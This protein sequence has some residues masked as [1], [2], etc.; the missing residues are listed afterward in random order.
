[1]LNIRLTELPELTSIDSANVFIYGA[2][3]AASNTSYKIRLNAFTTDFSIANAAFLQ[4]N[5]AYSTGFNANNALLISGLAF[6]QSNNAF[7]RSN[8]ALAL[9]TAGFDFANSVFIH[10]NSAFNRANSTLIYATAAFT[11]ANSSVIYTTAGFNTANAAFLRANAA[12]NAANSSGVLAQAAFDAANTAVG[13]SG[14]SHAEAAFKKANSANVIAQSS[15]NQAN[16]A[17]TAANN[18]VKKSGDTISG[19]VLAPTAANSNY[20]TQLAT[21]AFVQNSIS[22]RAV[23]GDNF[24]KKAGDTITGTVLAPT[25]A[26]SNYST[27]IATTAFVQNSITERAG[28]GGPTVKAYAVIDITDVTFNTTL[29]RGYNISSVSRLGTGRYLITYTNPLSSANYAVAGA[30]ST[31]NPNNLNRNFDHTIN[32]EATT[33]TSITVNTGDPGSVG[34]NTGQDPAKIWITVFE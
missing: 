33:T 8:N 29:T 20:S 16:A 10:A 14:F 11:F 12:F 28:G 2:N 4:A 22:L 24:V 15:F 32:I 25:A 30:V 27:Q 23:N 26:N 5:I 21:T 6:S 31:F 13:I 9:A 7:T 3:T 17:F 34:N 18:A 1:M 19:V